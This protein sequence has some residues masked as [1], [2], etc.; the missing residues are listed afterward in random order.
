MLLKQLMKLEGQ[1][2]Q[3]RIGEAAEPFTHESPVEG[4]DLADL[5]HGGLGQACLPL[6]LGRKHVIR[7]RNPPC[8]LRGDGYQ[9]DVEIM[10]IEG[11]GGDDKGR[12]HL[13]GRQI[14]ERKR[15]EDDI[16]PPKGGHKSRL[17]DCPKMR[18][19]SRRISDAAHPPV[20]AAAEP[21]DWT[22]TAAAAQALGS[23]R[24]FPASLAS[25][26]QFNAS[27]RKYQG[28]G[29]EG[30]RRAD[31]SVPLRRRRAGLRVGT[32]VGS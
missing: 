29:G 30:R 10:S 3:G 32:E 4:D 8:D 2:R 11:V 17:G 25:C 7:W 22:A 14:G 16:A 31:E 9:H 1:Q 24:L 19:T 13:G 5:H 28:G 21:A 23:G 6:I 26:S 18:R 12:P 27:F 20:R 15:D